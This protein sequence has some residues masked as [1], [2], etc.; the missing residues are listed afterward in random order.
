MATTPDF[1][2]IWGVDGDGD[3]YWTKIFTNTIERTFWIGYNLND[4]RPRTDFNGV[5]NNWTLLRS[6]GKAAGGAGWSV[7][8]IYRD[9]TSESLH[10]INE[11]EQQIPG[12]V[13]QLDADLIGNALLA[14]SKDPKV[15]GRSGGWQ[16]RN[17][18]EFLTEGLYR[19]IMPRSDFAEVVDPLDDAS[20]FSIIGGGDLTVEDDATTF[21]FG[22]SSIKLTSSSAVGTRAE[23]DLEV[24]GI[25][26][27][28]IFYIRSNLK[29]NFLTV[30]VGSSVWNQHTFKPD[31][32]LTGT[33][34]PI[35][36]DVSDKNI[37]SIGKFA[38]EIN[39]DQVIQ[40]KVQIDK[41][42]I[43]FSGHKTYRLEKK[44]SQYRYRPGGSGVTSE[45]GELPDS[46]PQY[47]AALQKI[48]Q[49]LRATQEVQ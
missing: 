33:F 38:I 41:L 15:S 6:Q 3:F 18:F 35:E 23:T 17:E 39:E 8:G 31:I 13:G 30:G 24:S 40:T 36:W 10:G 2:Y 48:T 29:G 11:D 26:K 32:A 28:I 20:K 7:A 12:F 27:K 45:F 19:F 25:I 37:R 43:V 22:A 9:P 47:V 1:F 21:M 16:A 5:V 14:D 34:I 42:D 44:R 46:L 49:E 4:F